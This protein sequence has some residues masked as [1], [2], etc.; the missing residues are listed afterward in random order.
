MVQWKE[1]PSPGWEKTRIRGMKKIWKEV[2]S[3]G[4]ERVRGRGRKK[5]CSFFVVSLCFLYFP[6]MVSA[7]TVTELAKTPSAFDQKPVM[8]VGEVANVVTR[9]GDKPYTTFDLLDAEDKSVSI[10]VWGKPTFKQGE[11]CRVAGKFVVEKK[12][13]T[14]ILARGV[15]ADKVEKLSTSAQDM[16]SVIFRKKKK[17]GLHA[18][19][20]F[21]IPQ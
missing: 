5:I 16:E 7:L 9:Y 14:H 3:P 13:E 10:F 1:V 17:T 21:Y 11:V 2:S 20:G 12:L 6:Q 15:E 18:P 8:V 19:R 4:W